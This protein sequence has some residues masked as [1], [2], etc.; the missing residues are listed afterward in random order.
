MPAFLFRHG[1]LFSEACQHCDSVEIGNIE[2]FFSCEVRDHLLD[3]VFQEFR[4]IMDG[5][6]ESVWDVIF[7]VNLDVSKQ[8]RMANVMTTEFFFRTTEFGFL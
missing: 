8:I 2:H 1:L 6:V 4:T 7:C 3:G 5:P